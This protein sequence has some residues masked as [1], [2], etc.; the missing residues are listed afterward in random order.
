[1]NRTIN[2][3]LRKIESESPCSCDLIYCLIR[4]IIKTMIITNVIITEILFKNSK[5]MLERI[6]LFS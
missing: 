2:F 3:D 6:S 1:M 5:S 4:I